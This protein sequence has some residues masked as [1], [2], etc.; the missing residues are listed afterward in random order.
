MTLFQFNKTLNAEEEHSVMLRCFTKTKTCVGFLC[1]INKK[2]SGK[3][4]NNA[5]RCPLCMDI[6]EDTFVDS[7]LPSQLNWTLPG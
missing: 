1:I 2:K 5:S 6:Y 4:K 7:T 3:D